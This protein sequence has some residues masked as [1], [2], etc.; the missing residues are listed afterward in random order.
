MRNKEISIYL[1][2]NNFQKKVFELRTIYGKMVRPYRCSYFYWCL[3][4][5]FH[6]LLVRISLNLKKADKK[7]KHEN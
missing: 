2:R 4:Y 1:Y 7:T 3:Y 5:R 6:L